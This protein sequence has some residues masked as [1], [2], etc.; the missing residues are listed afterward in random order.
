MSS[1]NWIPTVLRFTEGGSIECLLK[2]G[3]KAIKTLPEWEEWREANLLQDDSKKFME[4]M[5]A[6]GNNSDLTD[7]DSDPFTPAMAREADLFEVSKDGSITGIRH[8]AT[9]LYIMENVEVKHIHWSDKRNCYVLY[10]FS[11]KDGAYHIGAEHIIKRAVEKMLGERASIHYKS[12]IVDHIKHLSVVDCSEVMDINPFKDWVLFKNGRLNPLTREF[13]PGFDPKE[14]YLNPVPVTYDP[15]ATCPEWDSFI[16]TVVGKEADRRTLYELA[17]YCFMPGY[18]IHKAA[19]FVNSGRGG[20]GTYLAGLRAL[21]GSNN[22]TA[23]PLQAIDS[24]RFSVANLYGKRANIAGELSAG[25]LKHDSKFKG[26]TGGD[27]VDA[28]NKGE[29][30]FTFT[31]EA[32]CIFATNQVPATEDES[33]G[34]MSRW[35]PVEFVHNFEREG[36]MI[37]DFY[38]RLVTPSELSGFLNKAL[39]GLDRLRQQG[40]FSSAMSCDDVREWWRQKSDTV[41]YFLDES[42]GAVEVQ[43]IDEKIKD[44]TAPDIEIPV[45]VTP[46]AIIR[47]AYELFCK[48]ANLTPCNPRSF[49]KKLLEYVP[50]L[51]GG[52]RPTPTE[53]AENKI[54]EYMDDKRPNCYVGIRLTEKFKGKVLESRGKRAPDPKQTKIPGL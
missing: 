3:T 36:S 1:D 18:P 49:R 26:I 9:A 54:S 24:D 32:K 50:S 20:K 51:Y 19:I 27:V 28:E 45:P 37:P 2:D 41:Y 30:K 31:N 25:D 21:L 4:M 34:A 5:I 8:Q 48:D 29:N 11:K 13:K 39:D 40:G 53:K 12:E 23:V 47:E 17:G 33:D 7:S 10:Y 43:I 6:A 52:H 35:V 44:G 16:S 38:K 42:K 46:E 15:T 22:Y 14:I